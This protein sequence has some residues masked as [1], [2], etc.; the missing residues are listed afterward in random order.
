MTNKSNN[1]RVIQR[2]EMVGF[3]SFFDN[4]WPMRKEKES[5]SGA[6]AGLYHVFKNK[7]PPR[8]SSSFA[9]RPQ[10]PQ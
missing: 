4:W 8:Q 7:T 5:Q 3:I 2:A 6:R 1:N 10:R 9:L